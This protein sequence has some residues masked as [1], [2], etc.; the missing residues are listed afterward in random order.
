MVP[1]SSA[2]RVDVQKRIGQKALKQAL[3]EDCD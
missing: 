2:I 3:I 1:I